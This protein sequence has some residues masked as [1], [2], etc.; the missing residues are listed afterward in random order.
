M[1]SFHNYVV[2]KYHYMLRCDTHNDNNDDAGMECER[3]GGEKRR[4]RTNGAIC[5]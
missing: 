1:S 5:K 2:M 4:E 3:G